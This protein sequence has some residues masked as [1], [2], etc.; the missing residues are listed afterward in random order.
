MIDMATLSPQLP[1]ERI[2]RWDDPGALAQA[3]QAMSGRDFLDAIM[4]PGR[5]FGKALVHLS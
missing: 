2:I 4:L 3:G 5:N 1:R